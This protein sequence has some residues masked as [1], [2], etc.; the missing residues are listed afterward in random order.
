[1]THPTLKDAKAHLGRLIA[2]D[3]TSA[4]SNRAIVDH[5][6]DYFAELGADITILPDDTGE[7]AN[8]IARFG[9]AGTPGVVLSGHTDVV[10]ARAVNW[11]TP[12]FQMDERDGRLYGRGSCDMKGFAACVM[13]AAPEMARADLKRP[14]YLCFSH[15]EE[16]GCLG[17]PAIAQHLAAL[18]VPP[19]LAIIGEP[20][21]MKLVTGQKGKIAMRAHVRGT[22]GHSSFAPQHVNALEYAARIIGMIQDR[23][24]AY[25]ENGPF[26]H[27]FT[28]PHATMLATMIDGG[29]A[30]NVTPDRCT[31]TFE[32][33]SIDETRARADM[34]ALLSEVENRLLPEM[35]AI[36]PDTGIEWEEIFAYPAMGDATGTPG[37]EALRDILPEWGGKVSYG[38]EGGVFE[39]IGGIP[40]IIAGPGSIQ[41]AH[42]A[43]EFVEISQMDDCLHFLD[44]VVSSSATG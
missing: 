4:L 23:G 28:V 32:L 5:M 13:A 25:A 12:P 35:H 43:D 11:A 7:K 19:M 38:S 6:A 10:P 20:S 30:T 15:D 24:R 9:P 44:K 29:V 34:D 2:F 40:S 37:F 21:E 39:V 31:F 17:A 26:D 33:R 42:K 41:Q 3:T 27:D 1:M 8:L 36:S 18:D 22:A 16:V 14:L